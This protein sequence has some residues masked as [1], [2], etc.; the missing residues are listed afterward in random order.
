M[1]WRSG[2]D[3]HADLGRAAEAVEGEWESLRHP[4]LGQLQTVGAQSPSTTRGL[5][6]Q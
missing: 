6:W 2:E 3:S 1:T 4:A 5:F